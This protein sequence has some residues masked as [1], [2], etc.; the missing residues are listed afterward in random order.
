M[1]TKEQIKAELLDLPEE[2]RTEI[3]LALI[4][5]LSPPLHERSLEAEIDRRV[6]TYREN[7]SILIDAPTALRELK[8]LLK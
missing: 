2:E 4:R 6:A 3:A 1:E 5:S 7:P 8:K